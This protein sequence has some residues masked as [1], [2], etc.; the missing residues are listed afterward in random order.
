MVLTDS[1]FS[2]VSVPGCQSLSIGNSIGPIGFE[3]GSFQLPV[4][5]KSCTRREEGRLIR[6]EDRRVFGRMA[7]WRRGY[8]VSDS[9]SAGCSGAWI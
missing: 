7:S 8:R 9:F 3:R 6:G 1:R 5:I 4:E 2:L